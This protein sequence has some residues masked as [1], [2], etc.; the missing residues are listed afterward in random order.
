[1]C[2]SAG[3]SPELT[4]PKRD[5]ARRMRREAEKWLNDA[6]ILAGSLRAQSDEAAL[7]N[8]L[9][10]EV[11]LKC[12]LVLSDKPAR[13][14]H[15]YGEHWDSLPIDA[16][17]EIIRVARARS[18]GLAD[19]FDLVALF[20]DWRSFFNEGRYHYAL[21]GSEQEEREAGVTWLEADASIEH[22]RVRFH[23]EELF[24]LIEGLRAFIGARV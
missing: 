24:C 23:P 22:A 4:E 12:A 5:L 19:L 8:I 6:Q 15:R 7:L 18:P 3:N 17:Q 16:Q 14:H 20:C 13:R 1:M 11:L 10:F 2:T 21:Y 9:G